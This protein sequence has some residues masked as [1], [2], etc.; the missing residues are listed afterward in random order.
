[1][2]TH[3]LRILNF[4]ILVWIIPHVCLTILPRL[5]QVHIIHKLPTGILDGWQDLDNIIEQCGSENVALDRFELGTDPIET[6]EY[7]AKFGRLSLSSAY[8]DLAWAYLAVLYSG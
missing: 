1:M 2:D 7:C 3:I 8:S 6:D 5:F 4:R